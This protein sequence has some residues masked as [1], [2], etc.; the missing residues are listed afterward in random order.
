VRG[1]DYRAMF[2]ANGGDKK[3]LEV[4]ELTGIM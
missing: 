1:S 2:R 4:A 3:K